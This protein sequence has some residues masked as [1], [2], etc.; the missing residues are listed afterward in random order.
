MNAY[1]H[2]NFFGLIPKNEIP[3]TQTEERTTMDVT[4]AIIEHNA[5]KFEFYYL[6]NN[7]DQNKE[8]EYLHFL[9]FFEI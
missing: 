7:T 3:T 9:L 6:S 1:F 4:E 2:Q 5:W 8:S